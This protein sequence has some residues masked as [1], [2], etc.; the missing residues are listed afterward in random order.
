MITAVDTNVLLDILSGQEPLA[1]SSARALIEARR[2]G[3]IVAGDVVWAETAA[4]F[5]SASALDAAMDDLGVHYAAPTERVAALA[6]EIW[7]SYRADGGSRA[8]LVPDFLVGAHALV[9]ADRLMTR[10]RGFFR[11]CF[12]SLAIIDPSAD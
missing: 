3:A 2:A 5:P 11:R 12:S 8:R 9:Q 1:D 10:D 4:W 6:G 7:R